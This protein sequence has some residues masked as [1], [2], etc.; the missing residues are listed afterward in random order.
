MFARSHMMW[1]IESN[2]EEDCEIDDNIHNARAPSYC[3]YRAYV[4]LTT[5]DPSGD[6]IT[7]LTAVEPS[8]WPSK[9]LET[10]NTKCFHQ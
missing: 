2:W 3:W 10:V 5:F 6:E 1:C 7:L 8:R 9:L 4:G